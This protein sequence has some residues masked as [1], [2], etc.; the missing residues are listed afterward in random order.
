MTTARQLIA[1]EKWPVKGAFWVRVWIGEGTPPK[2][3]VSGIVVVYL[4]LRSTERPDWYVTV[5]DGR[6]KMPVEM[7]FRGGRAEKDP[8]GLPPL[9]DLARL[10]AWL[11]E[12]AR[13][14]GCK[15]DAASVDAGRAKRAEP[16]IAEWLGVGSVSKAGDVATP[17]S[18]VEWAESPA[19]TIY[20]PKTIAGERAILAK[21]LPVAPPLTRAQ[22]RA[23]AKRI[24]GARHF[25]L[26]TVLGAP[27][28]D[29]MRRALAAALVDADVGHDA[30]IRLRFLSKAIELA[31][32]ADLVAFEKRASTLFR[33]LR[34]LLEKASTVPVTPAL[35]EAA[36]AACMSF[37]PRNP[38]TALDTPADWLVLVLLAV[39]G[40]AASAKALLTVTHAQDAAAAK[41]G[42]PRARISPVAAQVAR[43]GKGRAF[44]EAAKQLEAMAN[45]A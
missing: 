5:Y 35:A 4:S 3:Y 37:V 43:V 11:P 17:T 45:G 22:A 1:S 13:K 8:L 2:A 38:P 33:P 32:P 23:V 44:A 20:D 40:S 27:M 25:V 10:P 30:P 36:R 12:I 6:G 42:D 26:T 19:P 39:D 7:T 14:L 34:V 24:V 21:L 28:P 15:L 18:V 31:P 29:T 9:D 16:A 41:A